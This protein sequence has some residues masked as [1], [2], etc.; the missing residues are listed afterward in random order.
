MAHQSWR[1][2]YPPL[3]SRPLA[4][5]LTG[6]AF[7]LTVGLAW[8]AI[9]AWSRPGDTLTR[10][11][12][13]GLVR[14]G[15]AQEA[16][17]AFLDPS[18]S[19][20]GESPELAIRVCGKI[21]LPRIQWVV[22]D[23]GDLLTGLQEGRVDVIAAGMFVTPERARIADFSMTTFRVTEGL[24]VRKGNP[25]SLHSYADAARVGEARVAVIQGSV[26]EGLL[27]RAGLPEARM[28]RAPDA[29]TGLLMVVS[30]SADALALSK[31]TVRWMARNEARSQVEAAEPFIA[32]P[33]EIPSPGAFVFRKAD[34]RFREAWNDGLRSF[35]G[36]REHAALVAPFG[37]GPD[38]LPDGR[39]E[40]AP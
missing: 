20:T 33:N 26:E 10:T 9:H 27:E 4:W 36:T 12:R 17:Y 6:A 23:F 2:R 29:K 34:V 35:L 28:R 15:Y 22:F 25:L 30:G 1:M 11:R 21:G 40:P 8:M 38:E 18:G 19:V 37:F 5:L 13:Q 16:P 3:A 32:Y 39:E 24:L 14:I 7:L 31:P